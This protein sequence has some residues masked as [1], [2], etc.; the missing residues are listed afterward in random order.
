METKE[1]ILL[2]SYK[3]FINNGY[4]NTSMQQLVNETKL[5][6]GAFYHHFRNKD[7]LYRQVIN[8]Y[9]LSFYKAID[10]DQYNQVKLTYKQIE[11]EIQKFYLNFV[12]QILSIT[13]NGMSGYYIMYFEAYNK[14]PEF[15][16][17]VQKF[18]SNLEALLIKANSNEGESLKKAT[19]IISK[20][21]GILFLLAIDPS[22][23]IE[24]LVAQ[25]SE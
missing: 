1:K 8:E 22:L 18:Y 24:K 25:I 2:T 19:Q 7:E 10:W 17:E 16:K 11:F 3:V 23:K 21:E 13:Q 9:F 6:K 14:L 4:H 15:K 12:P 5:S 20:Y